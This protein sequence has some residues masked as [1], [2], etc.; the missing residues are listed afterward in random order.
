MAAVEYKWD[1]YKL[2]YLKMVKHGDINKKL[3]FLMN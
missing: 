1:R 3:A 2:N